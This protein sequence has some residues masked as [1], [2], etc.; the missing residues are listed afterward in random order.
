M[1][2]A[3]SIWT[4]L[5]DEQARPKAE[6]LDRLRRI[7][8][9]LEHIH[10]QIASPRELGAE[11]PVLAAGKLASARNVAQAAVVTV[12]RAV[13]ALVYRATEDAPRLPRWDS[14]DPYHQALA[15]FRSIA[16]WPQ[17]P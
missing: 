3:S 13:N 15:A 9:Q 1:E 5:A 14:S 6:D 2:R 10:A 16:E 12:R 11:A 8:G 17:T 7:L 4:P